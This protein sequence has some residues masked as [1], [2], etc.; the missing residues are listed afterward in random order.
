MRPFAPVSPKVDFRQ[1]EE[2]VLAFWQQHN[3][4]KKSMA[5][6]Q[7]QK[8]QPWVFY[9]GPPTA[10]GLPHVGHVLTRV[11]KDLYPRYHAM[12]GR[13]VLRKAGW[14]TH[15]LPVEIEVEKELG[16]SGKEQIEAYGV[17][18]FNELCRASVFRYGEEWRKLTDRIGFWVDLDEAYVTMTNE[19][20]E[21]VWAILKTFWERD[22]LYQG[23]K[24]VPYCPRCGTPL[25]D[26]EVS[27]GYT[28]TEDPSIYVKFPLRDEPGVYFLVWTT[29]PW[30]LPAN[31]ALAV[32]PDIDYLRVQHG[33]DTLILAKALADRVFGEGNYTVKAE[34]KGRALTSTHYQPLFRFL[35]V[36]QDYA[37]VVEGDFVSI[38][39]GTGIVHIAPAFGADDLNMGRQYDLP[40]LVTINPQGNFISQVAPYAGQF[41]K[42]ADPQITA[43]LHDRGLLYHAG[44]YEHTYPFC[45]RCSTPLLYYARTTW[46]IETTRFKQ[47]L[48]DNNNKIN[49]VPD[50]IRTGRFGNWLENNID[51]ALGRERYWATPLPIWVC[52]ECNQMEAIGS[53]HELEAKTNQP[54]PDLDLHRP[55]IDDI[56]Y[57]CPAC[58]GSMQRVPEVID[59]WFDSGSMPY[60]QWHYPFENQATFEEQYPADFIS[61]AID[62]TRG[63]FYSLHAISTLLY[64][65]PAFKN[66]VVLGHVLDEQ[67]RKISKSKG[68]RVDPWDIINA[69]GVDAIRWFFV[70]GAQPWQSSRFGL[71]PVNEVVRKFMLTLWNTYSFFVTYANIALWQPPQPADQSPRS[72]STIPNL[73]DRWLLSELHRLVTLVDER[74]SSYDATTAGRAIGQFVDDLSNWY[75]RRNRRRFWE[76]DTAAFATLYEV[77]VT[78]SKLLA[79]LTPFLA[80]TLYRNLVA[81][82]DEAAPESVHLA[83]FPPPDP[84]LI[85]ETLSA[86]MALVQQVA[87]LGHAARNKASLK[88]RQPLAAVVV[89]TA[90]ERQRAALTS[91][92]AE[93][94]DELNVKALE[95]VSGDELARYRVT[96]N[97]AK[98]GPRL[99]KRLPALR[100]ALNQMET[101]PLGRTF[102]AGQSVTVELDGDTI[103]LAP[104]EVNV[105][106]ED[107]P[108]YAVVS[109]GGLTVAV[110]TEVTPALQR[111]GFARE[112]IRQFNQ[113]RKDAG[114]ALTD[115][116]TAWVSGPET[117]QLLTEWGDTIRAEILA[118]NL[119]SVEPPAEAT[120][121]TLTLDANQ[122]TLGVQRAEQ[123]EPK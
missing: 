37:Y 39:D 68:N 13:Y 54:L 80:E 24:V 119:Q 97:P 123:K 53:R 29:T 117:D 67:G 5:Q 73:L 2:A 76:G 78:L 122:V 83:D 60:A 112:L 110:R 115:R 98:L 1:T 93:L 57:P 32:G 88:V 84:R 89:S 61:E 120:T 26:H 11:Y 18:A 38:E 62:Q 81:R 75:V 49:W 16:L 91:L 95:L 99:G 108:G 87:S 116:I 30:T 41:F 42:E 14:D 46:Y 79:P 31:V 59:V 69:T 10:N 21:S 56:T 36:E 86:N 40:I 104:D 35:P 64:D 72:A 118:T 17:A 114:L 25:S 9:E 121:T 3:I 23:Y 47:Q 22:L 34:V 63:W 102:L 27:L 6:R 101:T 4:F 8:A 15:G 48:L 85:D 66:V 65:K 20:M 107:Q 103:T 111:E 96:L 94:L 105:L 77:L 90:D 33:D 100:Q 74:M 12:K 113:L 7:A 55:W 19:Y 92:Q 28:T 52:Q 71:A 44:I 109:E 70:T 45:W 50:H 51:W 82:I 43:D 58:G 106:A